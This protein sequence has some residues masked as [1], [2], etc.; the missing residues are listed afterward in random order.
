MSAWVRL[1]VFMRHE[2][3]MYNINYWTVGGVAFAVRSRY[4]RSGQTIIRCFF[5]R[6]IISLLTSHPM[7]SNISQESLFL[8]TGQ[9]FFLLMWLVCG[10]FM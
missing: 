2:G 9:P 4:V 6:L 5:A 3:L 1:Q 10:I 8:K 7:F